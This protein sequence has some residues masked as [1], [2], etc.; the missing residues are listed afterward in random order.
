MG[1]AEVSQLA[2]V[3]PNLALSVARKIEHPW[4]RCQALTS[5][6]EANFSIKN[7]EE[8]LEEAMSAA[9]NQTEP[10][11]VA[12]VSSW[13]LRQLVQINL[14]QAREHVS[15]LLEIIATEDHG[16]R[17]L[18]GLHGILWGVVGA[19]A[20]REHVFTRFTETAK[21]CVGWRAERIINSAALALAEYDQP[22]ARELLAARPD[23]R[24]TRPARTKLLQE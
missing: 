8:I 5:I 2:G 10:N 12:S 11:R 1:R 6:V 23:T 21:V 14:N 13:P 16:L 17:R 7:R 4:Y 9:Y 3:N 19:P 24:Y 22:S 18:D 20:L 15:R